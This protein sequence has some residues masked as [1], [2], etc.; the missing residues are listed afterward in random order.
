MLEHPPARKPGLQTST[1]CASR[2]LKILAASNFGLR[3]CKNMVVDPPPYISETAFSHRL[4][5]LCTPP[6]QRDEIWRIGRKL[7]KTQEKC[8]NP[9]CGCIPNVPET[10]PRCSLHYPLFS[11]ID[12][13]LNIDS[14]YSRG[15]DQGNPQ[16]ELAGVICFYRDHYLAYFHVAQSSTWVLCDDTH[17]RSMADFS[18]VRHTIVEGLQQPSV[19]FYTMKM[20]L[21][22][23]SLTHVS[24]K[25]S[26][27]GGFYRGDVR[28]SPKFRFTA[29]RPTGHVRHP[30]V[31][32][33]GRGQGAPN[34]GWGDKLVTS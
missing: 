17:L 16:Y 11:G 5:K 13:E 9:P 23:P 33:L 21:G 14:V 31:K 12:M 28:P 8:Q 34:R 3:F 32:L 6:P 10:Y 18:A 27:L 4:Q 29:G 24:R 26:V 22:G 1:S 25:W 19:L 2:S 15:S 30:L 7:H 20:P